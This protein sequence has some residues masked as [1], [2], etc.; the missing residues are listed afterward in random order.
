V[1][2]ARRSGRR[3]PLSHSPTN[4]QIVRDMSQDIPPPPTAV[5]ITE[6]AKK[7][8]NVLDLATIRETALGIDAA[9]TIAELEAWRDE[10][11]ATLAF[12]KAQRR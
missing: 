11:D 12:L 2:R 5:T 8:P 4:R 9:R 3:R 6:E 10:I 1:V 7:P